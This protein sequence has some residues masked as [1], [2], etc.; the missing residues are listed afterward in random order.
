LAYLNFYTALSH[1]T[2]AHEATLKNRYQELALAEKYYGAALAALTPSSG[3]LRCE[4]QELSSPCST[5]SSSSFSD[6]IIWKFRRRASNASSLDS[7][8]SSTTSYTSDVDFS[9]GGFKFPQPPVSRRAPSPT[10]ITS[11]PSTPE[12]YQFAADTAAFVRMVRG[13]LANVRNLKH[14][15]SPLSVRF[16]FLSPAPSPQVRMSGHLASEADE[17]MEMVRR[18]RR[19][20]KWRE[21]F[22]PS[23]VQRLCGEA[24]AE[25]S[26]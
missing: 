25:L 14:T 8:T 6:E 17:A 9:H 24:L 5:I 7:S 18:G 3:S 23:D 4:T 16:A 19:E 13:H 22:D 2:L 15:M 12:E 20:R 11:R 1:D 10:I 26:S 21:R